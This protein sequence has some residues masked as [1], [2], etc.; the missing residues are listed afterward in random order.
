MLQHDSVSF[1]SIFRS[2]ELLA[3]GFRDCCTLK[4]KTYGTKNM[5]R[6]DVAY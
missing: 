5:S 4:V 3:A 2:Q 1:N 6:R